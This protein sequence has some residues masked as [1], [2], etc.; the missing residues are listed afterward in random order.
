MATTILKYFKILLNHLWLPL[1]CWKVGCDSYYSSFKYSISAI[2]S[3]FFNDFLFIFDFLQ[4]LYDIHVCGFPIIYTACGLQCFLNLWFDVYWCGNFSTFISSII[5]SSPF[6]LYSWMVWQFTFYN[7]SLLFSVYLMLFSIYLSSSIVIQVLSFECLLVQKL[8]LCLWLISSSYAFLVGKF[9]MS[10][11][12]VEFGSYC[13]SF[14][15]PFLFV[16]IFEYQTPLKNKSF[17]KK[18][19][20][21]MNLKSDIIFSQRESMLTSCKHCQWHITLFQLRLRWFRVY[22]WSLEG[23][24][25]F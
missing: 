1:F 19:K 9:L 2:P 7:F 6:S 18:Y 15:C 5:A 4:L 8:L 14:I 22:L 25:Y 11:I 20:S 12:S 24:V 10:I 23:Q 3:D 16:L 13:H 17:F 21:D